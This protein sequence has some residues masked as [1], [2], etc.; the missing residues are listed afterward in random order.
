MV[1]LPTA[2]PAAPPAPPAY[3]KG[4]LIK[5][6]VIL[7]ELSGI[8]AHEIATDHEQRKKAYRAAVKATHSDLTGDNEKIVQVNW[9]K[10]I[11]DIP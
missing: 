10:G 6:A 4:E 7:S 2:E 1:S 3:T 5:A 11:L 8:P 9:A